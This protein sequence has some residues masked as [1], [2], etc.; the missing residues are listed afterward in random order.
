MRQVFAQATSVDIKTIFSPA[1]S[2]GT[3]G[4]LVS[5]IVQNAFV[6]A[7]VICL[8]LWI[9]GGF[10]IIVGAGSG[11]TKRME[12]GRQAMSGAVIGLL[13]IVASVWI[14]QIIEKIT[15]LSLMSPGK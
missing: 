13:V 8:A 4:D 9:F 12:Q 2:F 15:G 7:G 6:I 10:G 14:V 1:Q 3:F 11:D 5:V